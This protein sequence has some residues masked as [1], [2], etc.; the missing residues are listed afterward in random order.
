VVGGGGLVFPLMPNSPHY[1]PQFEP[2]LQGYFGIDDAHRDPLVHPGQFLLEY[3]LYQQVIELGDPL[4]Y[5]PYLLTHP[6]PNQP[7]KHVLL[8]EAIADESVPNHANEALARGLG[9]PLI[10]HSQSPAIGVTH[11]D[12]LPTD[13]APLAGNLNGASAGLL[14]FDPA[15]HGMFLIQDDQRHYQPIWPPL[16]PLSA[17]MQVTEP[18]SAERR[19]AL[20]FADTFYAGTA[21][22]QVID[23]FSP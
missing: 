11:V 21:A 8:L 18:S 17:P 10:L 3:G 1:G 2:P 12:P 19:L 4:A 20:Q 15:T 14:Q 6:L 9:L 7:Q 23:P 22:P 13:M 16:E 5:A